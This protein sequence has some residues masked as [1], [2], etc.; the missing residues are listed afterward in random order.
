M[1]PFLYS[2]KSLFVNS[3]LRVEVSGSLCVLTYGDQAYS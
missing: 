2:T 1:F 3:L